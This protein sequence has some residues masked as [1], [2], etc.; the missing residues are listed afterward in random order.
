MT[1]E[2][3]IQQIHKMKG[4][5]EE[6]NKDKIGPAIVPVIS[7]QQQQSNNNVNIISSNASIQQL[8]S[9]SK[10]ISKMPQLPS[11]SSGI[12]QQPRAYLPPQ[13]TLAHHPNLMQNLNPAMMNL[14]PGMPTHPNLM[15]Q[16]SIAGNHHP[17]PPNLPPHFMPHAPGH[18]PVPPLPEHQLLSGGMMNNELEPA[19][20]KQRIEG[21]LLPEEE[22][23]ATH[24]GNLTLTVNVPNMPDKPELN[25]NGQCL[26]I[27]LNLTDMVSVIKNKINE[28]IGLAPGKQKLQYE[29]IFIKDSNTLAYY[30]MS[31]SSILQLA[32]KERGGRK[33]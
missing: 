1:I 30:N 23:L 21:N 20:K 27:T 25:M 7:Q 2:D 24:S 13:P 28:Q 32:L 12:N 16:H 4:L 8:P 33:K 9:N 10:I 15:Q 19:H 22:W 31:D 17:L 26:S 18:L 11:I 14:Y 3:Q 5:V 6:D 29:G